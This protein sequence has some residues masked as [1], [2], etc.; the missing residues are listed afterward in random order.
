MNELG[1]IRQIRRLDRVAIEKDFSEEEYPSLTDMLKI[2]LVQ[3]LEELKS[4]AELQNKLK[5]AGL[6]P[7][8][9]FALILVAIPIVIKI[10][11]LLFD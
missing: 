8:A 4:D 7:L 5:P 1:A 2:E 3:R 11:D 9:M 10:L 6:H